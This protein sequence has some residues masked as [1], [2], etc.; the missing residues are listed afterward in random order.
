MV[1][2]ISKLQIRNE[3]VMSESYLRSRY[4]SSCPR[5]V[6]KAEVRKR[7]RDESS[8]N[9]PPALCVVVL[10]SEREPRQVVRRA[11]D[12]SPRNGED[13]LAQKQPT[14]SPTHRRV[15]GT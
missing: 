5:G 10:Q 7:R 6:K 13:R 2:G 11:Q 9:G 3:T 12:D 14:Q 15:F 4:V 1:R 8:C